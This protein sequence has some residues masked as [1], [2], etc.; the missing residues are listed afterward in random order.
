MRTSPNRRKRRLIRP[1]GP[2][3]DLMIVIRATPN[4]R[5]EAAEQIADSASLSARVYVIELA[6]G[7]RHVLFG[8]SVFA[9]P[10]GQ[11]VSTVLDR[12]AAAPMFVEAPVGALRRAGFE[13][14]PTGEN[15]NHY[16]IQ[17]LGGVTEDEPTPSDEVIRAAA[18]R[19]LDAAGDLRP[20]PSYA[21]SAD[22]QSEEE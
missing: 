5:T 4:S 20:N 13:V 19:L 1:D 17:L 11:D 16:D 6:E 9:H 3:D 8:V 22:N 21:G 12:F 15:P 2:P 7:I 14:L 18:A 10:D